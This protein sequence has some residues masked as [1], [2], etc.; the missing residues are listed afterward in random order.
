MATVGK[1]FLKMALHFGDTEIH[2]YSLLLAL[3][4]KIFLSS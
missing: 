3:D 2:N 1:D 4:N